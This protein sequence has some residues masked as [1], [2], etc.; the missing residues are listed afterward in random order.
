MFGTILVVLV[1]LLLARKLY[2]SRGSSKS[3]EIP[4]ES[5]LPKDA[6][7]AF[8]VCTF[9]LL[10]KLAEIDGR[11]ERSET[12]R[13]ERYIYQDLQL[14]AREAKLALKV[15]REAGD[16]PLELNDY[17]DT[18]AKSF[19]ERVQILDR[20]VRILLEVSIA[21]GS[22]SPAEEAAIRS[23]ALRLGLS[24]PGFDRIRDELCGPSKMVH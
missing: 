5:Q 9:S 21:D 7:S 22:L 17:A 18:F 10:R 12:S 6:Q 4:T 16:S 1:L 24:P 11:V 15:Y 2:F 23:A 8:I 13:V 20:M 3:K 14:S 19:S